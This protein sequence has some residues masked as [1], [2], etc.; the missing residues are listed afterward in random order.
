MKQKLDMS[1]V[2][3][4][5]T[6]VGLMLPAGF[7]PRVAG[8]LNEVGAIVERED[9]DDDEEPIMFFVRVDSNVLDGVVAQRRNQARWGLLGVLVGVGGFLYTSYTRDEFLNGAWL[10]IMMYTGG[11]AIVQY[12]VVHLRQD[13]QAKMRKAG[14]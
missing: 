13:L 3:K 2:E 10:M 7:L 1:N 8:L 6:P 5:A 14:L 9:P 12:R 11:A 4:A